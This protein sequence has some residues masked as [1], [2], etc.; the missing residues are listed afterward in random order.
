MPING[1]SMYL[2][3]QEFKSMD[4]GVQGKDCLNHEKQTN[5][6]LNDQQL[7][8][9]LREL[10]CI[11]HLQRTIEMPGI[12]LGEITQELVNILPL[13]ISSSKLIF[14]RIQINSKT[15]TCP[16]FKSTVKL[17]QQKIYCFSEQIGVLELFADNIDFGCNE[18]D[19]KLK[20]NLVNLV[21]SMLGHAAERFLNNEQKQKHESAIDQYSSALGTVMSKV[22]QEKNQVQEKIVL[23]IENNLIPIVKKI[24]NINGILNNPNKILAYANIIEKELNDITNDFLQKFENLK[25]RLTPVELKVCHYIKS[26]YSAKEIGDIL[27]SSPNTVKNHSNN[28]RRKLGL[29]NKKVSLK[30]YVYSIGK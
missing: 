16:N 7:N 22:D 1:G 18:E 2:D 9:K 19:L 30:K 24:Q 27:G 5:N 21:T 25:I 28:I 29:T 12:T 11:Y 20:T 10:N 4:D 13:S 6:S 26:G 3:K 17:A 8:S 15:F 23:N 14:T